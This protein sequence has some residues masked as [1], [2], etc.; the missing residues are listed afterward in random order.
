MLG[1]ALRKTNP[2]SCILN[3]TK[4]LF[5]LLGLAGTQQGQAAV[6]EAAFVSIM[7]YNVHGLPW[8]FASGR[9]AAF[10][11]IE[12]RLRALRHRNAQPNVVV[13]QEAFTQS[14]KAIGT[15]SGYRYIVDGPSRD[16]VGSQRAGAMDLTFNNAASFFKGE[17]SGKW[18][19]SGLQI[20]SDYP[21]LSVKRQAFPTYACAGFDC[22]ANKGILLVTIAIPGS[23]TPILIATTHMNSKHASGVSVERSYYAYQRQADMINHFLA[24]NR[25]PNAPVVFAGD[26]NA[27]SDQRKS[28]LLASGASSLSAA[29]TV[30]VQSA[31]QSCLSASHPCGFA[32]PQIAR[33]IQKRSRDWQLYA[34]GF[35]TSIQAVKMQVPFGHERSGEMLSDHI[36]YGIVYRLNGAAPITNHRN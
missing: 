6:P 31:L 21:I 4:L 22:L 32:V 14:A 27:S 36:G 35:R 17:T 11:R 13:L 29:S 34:N 8:P 5:V 18:L 3:L 30:K 15:K 7:T 26:F 12:G 2:M 24:A 1:N 23:T 25:D 19:D 20:L 28:Y 10:Q 16:S 33:F 9:D